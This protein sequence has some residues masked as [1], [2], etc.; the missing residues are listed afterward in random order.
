MDP[1]GVVLVE[2]ALYFN[3]IHILVVITMATL[4]V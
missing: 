4:C 1:E 2:D 3:D